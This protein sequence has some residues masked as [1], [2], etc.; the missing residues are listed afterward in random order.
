MSKTMPP[1]PRREPGAPTIFIL[2]GLPATGKST[3]V[4]EYFKTCVTP[5]VVASTD[6]ILERFAA[7]DGTSYAVAHATRFKEAEKL[8]KQTIM[9]AAREGKDVIVD[10]TNVFP[11][12]R[13]KAILLVESSTRLTY[14]RVAVVFEQPEEVIRERL[15]VREAETGKHVPWSAIESMLEGH[16]EPRES[17][18][19]QIRYV[20]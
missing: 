15:A 20:R 17:D 3:W 18:Y 2:V 14:R 1:L 12:A 4:R 7:E 13:R 9:D 19:H 8:F 10:R 6:D 11:S 5:T 16:E